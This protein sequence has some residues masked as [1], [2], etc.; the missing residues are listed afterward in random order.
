MNIT[1]FRI[2]ERLIHGQI[3]TA[4]IA[5]AEANQI[6]VADDKAANDEFQKTLLQL[7]TPKNINLKI[8]GVEDAIKMIK[9]DTSDTKVL[10]LVRGPKEALQMIEGGVA[11]KE[12][13]IGNINMKKGKTKVLGNLWIDSEDISNLTKLSELGI[14]LDIRTVPNE[15]SQD[16][17]KLIHK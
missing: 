13:N 3:V 14:S 5:Y 11:V 6:I 17:M 7:A 16:A 15:R 10:L 1:V 9:E 8:L 4:W 2:D 12:I